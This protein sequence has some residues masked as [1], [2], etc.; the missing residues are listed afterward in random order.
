MFNLVQSVTND[1]E[2]P[3]GMYGSRSRHKVWGAP[4]ARRDVPFLLQQGLSGLAEYF[5][6]T[7]NEHPA[8]LERHWRRL[9]FRRPG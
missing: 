9:V 5:M 1:K 2:I 8:R 7:A 3:R 4:R 6:R